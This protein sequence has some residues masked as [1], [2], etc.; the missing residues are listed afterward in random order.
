MKHRLLQD[1]DLVCGGCDIKHVCTDR[2][3]AELAASVVGDEEP[4]IVCPAIAC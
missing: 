1:P 4:R 3:T 2:H